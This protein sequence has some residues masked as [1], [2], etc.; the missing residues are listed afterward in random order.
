VS[1]P[2]VPNNNQLLVS[3]ATENYL[4]EDGEVGKDDEIS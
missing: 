3:T 2:L 4:R 1:L